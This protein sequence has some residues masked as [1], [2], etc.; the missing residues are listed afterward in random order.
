[1]ETILELLNLLT[2]PQLEKLHQVVAEKIEQVADAPEQANL[3]VC[4]IEFDDEGI[5][6]AVKGDWYSFFPSTPAATL[7][8]QADLFTT[9]EWDGEDLG[10]GIE[11]EP[12]HVHHWAVD[13][14][15]AL[16]YRIKVKETIGWTPAFKVEVPLVRHF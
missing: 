6:D 7:T 1:M 4:S 2:P 12:V 10:Y 3:K 16:W 11:N 15:C 5:T 8:Q 13:I 14:D 9:P